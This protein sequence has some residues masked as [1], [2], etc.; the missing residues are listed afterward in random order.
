MLLHW[1]WDS[2]KLSVDNPHI[3]LLS[4][5]VS[6][7][8]SRDVKGAGY[9]LDPNRISSV[10]EQIIKTFQGTSHICHQY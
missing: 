6:C 5:D 8:N 2:T 10:I 1:M 9:F 3:C 4:Q 7:L